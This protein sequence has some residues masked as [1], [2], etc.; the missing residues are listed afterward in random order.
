MSK[1]KKTKAKRMG[2]KALLAHGEDKLTMTTFGKG[3]RSQIEFTEGYH[4]RALETPKRFGKRGFEVRKIDENVDLYGDLDEGKTIEA[5]LVNPSENVGEDYLKL[6]STLENYFFGR[7]FPHDN[8]RI[9]LIYNILDIYKILGMNVADILYTLGNLQDAEGDID[10]FGKS[11]NNEDNIKE[12]LNR[13]RPYMGYFG[14]VFKKD[15]REHNKKVLRCISALR[16]ATAHGKQDEYPWFK[17]SDIYEKTIFKADKWRIIEDQYREKIRKVNNEFFSKNKVNLA[18]LFDLLHARDVEPKKQIA[19]EFYR[20][21]IRKDGKNLGMN[22]VK[23]REKII[24]RFARDL[25]DKKHDPHRQKIH[26]IADF[27][28]FRALS[29]NQ[30]VIDKTVSRLRLTKDEEEKDRV[31]QNAAELVWGMVSNCLSPYFKDPKKY[32]IQYKSG[33]K[34]KIFDDWITSKI[35]AKDGEPFV[36]VLSFLCNF[37]EGKEINELLTAYIHKFECIQDFL[38]VISSLGER[39]Q[40]QPRFDL[41]NKPDFAQNVAVQLRILASIGKMKPDLTEAKRP[42]YKAAIQMLCP[43]EKWEKYT[44][45]EWLEENMLLN[46]EDRQN[47][48]KREKVNP[49][50]NFIA[51]NV[52]ES[53]RFMYLVRY[54]KPKAVRALM[55]NRSVVNYVLHRL[56]PEQIKTYSRVF[57][58][59]FN[60][61]EAEIDFLVNKLSEFSFETFIT[62]RQTILANSKRG[63]SPN[64]RETAEEIERLKAITGLYLSVAYIAIKNIVKANARYYIAFAVFERDKELVKAKDARIQTTI[65]N[66]TYT[67]YFCLTQYYLD[68]DE[69]KKFQGDPRDKE[70]FFEHLRKKKTHFSKQW[71]EWLNEKIADAKSAQE[72][73]LLL[74]EARNDVEHL[75][76]LRAIPDYIQDFRHGDKGETPMNSYFELYH[77]L[78]Q[79]LMLKNRLLDLSSWRSWIERS[80]RPDRDLIQIAFVSLAYNLPRYR[81]LTKEHHF[82]DTVLQ[83]IRERKSL[84]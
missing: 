38:K 6:K 27:L 66:T 55:K 78:L 60:D 35:S 26:V 41:F 40:F 5:L 3:N 84:D 64:R 20:F 17:S 34:I 59:D 10:L 4:G 24:D 48:E 29:Q 16:N 22:L 82:D 68:R 37:L 21:T 50:R 54:S 25:R 65:P 58:D 31:Y 23:I 72:T 13:M 47:K 18:I 32:I 1:D 43:P 61:T 51:G 33:G 70:A 79:R 39:A 2:V 30:E 80:G 14:E 57:P 63:F 62:S 71:R 42:L 46:S 44:S 8:I 67:N 7:E 49:F 53:R 19:D 76:V 9:Q 15:N 77:Y 69:E 75:N 81:N 73:G 11:L 45:D 28:I 52:I 74:T 12:S 83:K 36:K 56:P